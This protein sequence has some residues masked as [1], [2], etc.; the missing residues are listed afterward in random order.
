MNMLETDLNGAGEPA[1][2]FHGRVIHV[3]DQHFRSIT[4]ETLQCHEKVFN[5]GS[6]S[7]IMYSEGYYNIVNQAKRNVPELSD[8]SGRTIARV[9]A[10]TFAT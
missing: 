3:D 2:G 9:L 7:G 8:A 5:D 4:E 10:K 6:A 1:Q